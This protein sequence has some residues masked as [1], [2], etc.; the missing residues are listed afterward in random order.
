MALWL[1]EKGS[2][3]GMLVELQTWMITHGVCKTRKKK[4]SKGER[5]KENMKKRAYFLIRKFRSK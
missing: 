5:K 4:G 2:G 1:A 3:G